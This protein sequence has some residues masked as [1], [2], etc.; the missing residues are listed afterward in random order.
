MV[1]G[2]DGEPLP[3]D[4][5][6]RNTMDKIL[7][8]LYEVIVLFLAAMWWWAYYRRRD[9]RPFLFLAIIS[10]LQVANYSVS[11]FAYYWI[12]LYRAIVYTPHPWINTL[13][14]GVN[15]PLQVL[16]A[17]GIFWLVTTIISTAH[18]D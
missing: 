8:G 9:I 6:E 18:D 4:I 16:N 12:D 5:I 1:P 2:A 3:F 7:V 10:S 15:M 13:H 14:Q 11:L 17:A